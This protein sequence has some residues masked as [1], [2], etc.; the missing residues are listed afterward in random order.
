MRVVRSLEQKT[1]RERVAGKWTQ[2]EVVEDWQW[3]VL[4]PNEQEPPTQLVRCWGHARWEQE[5]G[6]CE[7]TQ[8][9]HL[10]HSYH[11]HPT[12]RIAILLIL[13]QTFFFT[14]VFF[15]RKP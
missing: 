10:D 15:D 11:H 12:A 8:H 14:T 9:W 2:R 13:F 4:F 5:E 7:L 3:A 6:F 1:Q